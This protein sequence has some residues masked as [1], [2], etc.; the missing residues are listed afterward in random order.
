[1]KAPGEKSKARQVRDA[2]CT[3][4]KGR[5]QLHSLIPSVHRNAINSALLDMQNAGAIETD[6]VLYWLH[7]S[8]KTEADYRAFMRDI[9]RMTR[10]EPAINPDPFAAGR[11]AAVNAALLAW[12]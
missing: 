9:R 12:R 4:P 5:E 7:H 1:M 10:G 11:A 3:G 8:V 2:L 6:G